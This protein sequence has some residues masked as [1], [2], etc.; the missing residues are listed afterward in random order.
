M[1][2]LIGLVAVLAAWLNHDTV[3]V[4]NVVSTLPVVVA[5][6]RSY[7]RYQRIWRRLR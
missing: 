2:S 3:G 5:A 7:V 6:N 1:G 4:L